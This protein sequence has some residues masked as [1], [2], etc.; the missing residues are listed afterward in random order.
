MG[1]SLF[2]CIMMNLG[3]FFFTLLTVFLPL[4]YLSSRNRRPAVFCGVLQLQGRVSKHL[5]K[6]F[7]NTQSSKACVGLGGLRS[8]DVLGKTDCYGKGI[9]GVN[10][11]SIAIANGKAHGDGT[12]AL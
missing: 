6:L 12:S 10:D 11:S 7:S 5:K 1:F 8:S 9:V 3:V 4:H 2:A